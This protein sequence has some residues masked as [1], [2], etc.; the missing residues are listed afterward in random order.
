MHECAGETNQDV[1][2]DVFLLQVKISL[3]AFSKVS[4][5]IA[6]L[7]TQNPDIILPARFSHPRSILKERPGQ[8]HCWARPPVQGP[9]LQFPRKAHQQRHALPTHSYLT[10]L[11]TAHT[12]L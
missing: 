5:L 4:P 7:S 12:D 8:R 9:L 3:K 10:N 11:T 2:Y 1:K 6:S